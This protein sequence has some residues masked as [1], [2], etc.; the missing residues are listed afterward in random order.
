MRGVSG[1]CEVG[2]DLFLLR[3]V[4]R[5]E[6]V[7]DVVAS[8]GIVGTTLVVGEV[9][10]HGADGQLLLETIDL[11]QEE[12]DGRLDE[13]TRVADRVEQGKRLL[14]TVDSLV[15]EQQLVVLGDGDQEENSGDV[16][17][18][19]NPLLPFGTLTTDIEHAVRQ[20]ANEESSLGDTGRLDTRAQNILVGGKVVGLSNAVDGVEVAKQRR[21]A[22]EL[23]LVS[24]SGSH[25][26][27]GRVVELVLAGPL[28]A[29]L[30]T[31]VAPESANGTADLWGQAVTFD[32]SGLHEDGLHV[33]FVAGVL[34]G[35]LERLHGLQDDTHRLNRVAVDDFLEGFPF[36]ARVSTLVDQ[37]HLLQNSRLAGLSSSCG[38]S[39]NEKSSSTNADIILSAARS[40]LDPRSAGGGGLRT[41]QK[42]LNLIPLQHLVPLELVL[43][44]F[45]AGLALL[46]FGTHSTTHFGGD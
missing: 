33:V 37:L 40:D 46:I 4:E 38:N 1:T 20:V 5:H 16:F 25:S 24:S 45:V 11:V 7:E 17:E 3:L 23:V 42:H 36:I 29:L 15:L 31:G 13:P 39:V 2:V 30:D 18:A 21:S 14:H 35:K 6:A 22:I 12:N 34:Q 43:N 28:E 8:G 32:L 44:L 26:L 19:V 27:F 9:V 10:L 41:E